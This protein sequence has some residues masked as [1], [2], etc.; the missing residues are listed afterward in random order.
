MSLKHKGS[1][2]YHD[3]TV[4][5][6]QRNVTSEQMEGVRVLAETIAVQALVNKNWD[7]AHK[8]L[9]DAQMFHEQQQTLAG[10]MSTPIAAIL[11][12]RIANAVE[13]GMG[14]N[15]IATFL[16]VE[17]N[18]LMAIPGFSYHSV[19]HCYRDMWKHALETIVTM[20]GQRQVR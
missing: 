10:Y 9:S 7:A 13:N 14:T 11:D 18:E 16:D 8:L 1:V 12:T 6:V 19:I 15:T 17:V 3:P 5:E 20:E 2:H 4:S